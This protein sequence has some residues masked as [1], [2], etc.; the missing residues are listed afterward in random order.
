M[1]VLWSR[2]R[3]GSLHTSA[4]GSKPEEEEVRLLIYG[5][6]MRLI[7]ASWLKMRGPV[8]VRSRVKDRDT[9]KCTGQWCHEGHG[10]TRTDSRSKA[11][12]LRLGYQEKLF[13]NSQQP[14]RDLRSCPSE[15]DETLSMW[16]LILRDGPWGTVNTNRPVFL[17]SLNLQMQQLAQ[18]PRTSVCWIEIVTQDTAFALKVLAQTGHSDFRNQHNAA[19][20]T[21]AGRTRAQRTEDLSTNVFLREIQAGGARVTSSDHRHCVR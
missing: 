18:C 8:F 17:S 7:A 13:E 10:A 11:G 16:L 2:K 21:W 19:C 6:I 12:W 14:K 3:K 1:I 20:Q 4:R 15:K 9:A 5:A